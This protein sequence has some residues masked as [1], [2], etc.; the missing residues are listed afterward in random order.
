MASTRTLLYLQ[1]LSVMLYGGDRADTAYPLPLLTK[2]INSTIYD[3][4]CGNLT[5]PMSEFE[6]LSKLNLSFLEKQAW[7]KMT[8]KTYVYNPNLTN[9]IGSSTLTVSLE[10]QEYPTSGMLWVNS[11][12]VQYTGLTINTDGTVTFT[13]IP[14]TGEYSIQANHSHNGLVKGLYTLPTDY[15]MLDKVFSTNAI[16]SL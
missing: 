3:F 16:A 4:C 14:T 9:L 12:I 2:F 15:M 1:N 10:A 8:R 13:G 5:N 6:A 7:Y 11:D